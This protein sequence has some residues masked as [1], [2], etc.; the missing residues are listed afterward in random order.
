[1]RRLE[2]R[3]GFSTLRAMNNPAQ[4]LQDDSYK[5]KKIVL[6]FSLFGQIA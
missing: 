1:L 6:K 5:A 2:E 3:S 4:A